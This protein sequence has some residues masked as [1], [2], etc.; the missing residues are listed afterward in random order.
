MKM[1][2][3]EKLADALVV[4]VLILIALCVC[5]AGRKLVRG[6]PL[7]VDPVATVATDSV[8]ARIYGEGAR[9]GVFTATSCGSDQDHPHWDDI[10]WL[11]DPANLADL[12]RYG[13]GY[14]VFWGDYLYTNG[15]RPNAEGRYEYLYPERVAAAMQAVRLVGCKVIGYA[16]G[17]KWRAAGL[18]PR[19]LLAEIERHGWDGVF[20]DNGQVGR[21][22]WETWDF[23][24]RLKQAGLIVIVHIDYEDHIGMADYRPPW[25]HLID[26]VFIGETRRAPDDL[27]EFMAWLEWFGR[28][29][30]IVIYMT[31]KRDGE[32]D[33]WQGRQAE[34]YPAMAETG[35]AMA[36][37]GSGEMWQTYTEF[38]YPAWQRAAREW[39]VAELRPVMV[40]DGRDV[41]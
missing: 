34:W 36:R 28:G 2:R 3:V 19:Q 32:N 20:L 17:P 8:E 10:A 7:L 29:H 41:K 35:Y 37:A 23:Y 40:S 14:V 21:S 39:R 5:L 30:S 38:W 31:G 22:M 18:T 33:Q 15:V 24:V 11:T 25:A 9:P 27:D 12:Q 1:A 16:H 4:T 13:I 6:E 26:Y